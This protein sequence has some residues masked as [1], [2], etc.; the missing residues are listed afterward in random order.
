MCFPVRV[1]CSDLPDGLAVRCGAS[2][3][4][5]PSHPWLGLRA[6]SGSVDRDLPR[7]ALKALAPATSQAGQTLPNAREV[8]RDRRA[9][10]ESPGGTGIWGFGSAVP[11]LRE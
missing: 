7:R 3:S 10:P 11:A 2:R 8:D 9:V 5:S 4:L 6:G 1:V